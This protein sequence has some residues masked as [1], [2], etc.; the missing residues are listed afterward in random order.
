MIAHF[1][2]LMFQ[3][4]L[5]A[6]AVTDLLT[7]KI[8]NW[9]SVLLVL[10]FFPACWIVGMSLPEVGLSILAGLAVFALCFGLFAA[11]VMGGGDAKLLSAAALWFGYNI[12]LISFMV[13]VAFAGGILTLAILV[14]RA[15]ATTV[16][17]IGLRLPHSLVS[18]KK[19]PYAIAIAA[20]GILSWPQAPLLRLASLAH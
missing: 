9:I 7:M 1:L 11:N 17:A 18:A 20:G 14:L 5:C 15:N 8:P 13:T 19:I 12:S 10:L 3:A 2:P 4:A 6:A 16:M